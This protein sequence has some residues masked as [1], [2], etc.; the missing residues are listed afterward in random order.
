MLWEPG[1]ARRDPG[2]RGA[3]TVCASK[4][5]I[6]S[7]AGICG[8]N[9]IPFEAGTRLLGQLDKPDFIGREA[10]LRRTAEGP[11]TGSAS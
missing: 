4:R 11:R 6:G 8:P 7:T 2:G 1:T 3:S 5:A 9:T 10:L